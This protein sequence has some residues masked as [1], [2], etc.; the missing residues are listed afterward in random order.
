MNATH[1][2]NLLF[3]DDSPTQR[4]L[5]MYSLSE[6]GAV[7]RHESTPAQAAP[8]E[9]GRLNIEMFVASTG[10]RAIELLRANPID[11]LVTDIDMP[12]MNGWEVTQQALQIKPSLQVMIV[13]STV[14]TH[15]A[16]PAPFLASQVRLFSKTDRSLAMKAVAEFIG[17]GFVIGKDPGMRRHALA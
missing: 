7:V 10:R 14:Q 5:W 9:A 1:H 17:D 6:S 8:R 3:V 12:D 13:S 2:V 15:G 16:P 4:A 11:M